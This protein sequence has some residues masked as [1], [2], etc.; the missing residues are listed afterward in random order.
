M[1][2]N[3]VPSIMHTSS[4]EKPIVTLPIWNSALEMATVSSTNTM[5]ME[6]RL[7]LELNSFSIC[8]RISPITAPSTAFWLP[9]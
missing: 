9:P 1:L 7:L 2:Q 4:E 3:S 6:R 8:V 5:V